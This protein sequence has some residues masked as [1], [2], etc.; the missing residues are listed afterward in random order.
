M[1]GER[2]AYKADEVSVGGVFRGAR[3][4]HRRSR[5][6]YIR[7]I[8]PNSLPSGWRS[9]SWQYVSKKPCQSGV[10][11]HDIHIFLSHY[12]HPCGVSIELSGER[13]L[14]GVQRAPTDPLDS[15]D[16]PHLLHPPLSVVVQSGTTTQRL[17]N[18][19]TIKATSDASKGGWLPVR[20]KVATK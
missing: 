3:Y 8:E 6:A 19:G 14:S 1:C 7:L 18:V 20:E 2:A 15:E 16:V 11:G 9:A 10:G 13:S 17:K 5:Q 12:R 4:A